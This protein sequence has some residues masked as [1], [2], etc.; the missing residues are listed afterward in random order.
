MWRTND[1]G[2]YN[3]P[4]ETCDV[5]TKKEVTVPN[6][7]GKTKEDA[8]KIL[9]DLGLTVTV[10][11]EESSKEDGTVINQSKKEGSK[12]TAG[13]NITITI[14]KKKEDT[15]S[16]ENEIKDNEI[17]DPDRPGDIVNDA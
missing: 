16:G 12:A 15:S 17:E 9:K 14:S 6:V 5:H 11:T 7:I 4:T 10:E 13:D 8:I 3:I 2:K 1:G